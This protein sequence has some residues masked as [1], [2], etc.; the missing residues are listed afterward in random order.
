MA[1]AGCGRTPATPAPAANTPPPVPASTAIAQAADTSNVTKSEEPVAAPA[2]KQAGTPVADSA[3]AQPVADD[4]P[5]KFLLFLPAG[6]LIVQLNMTIDGRPFH[7]AREELVDEV[8][9]LADADHDGNPTWN[10]IVADSKEAL[11]RRFGLALDVRDRKEF[12]RTH[13]TNQN[14]VLDRDEARRLVIRAKNA[15]EAFAL[16]SSTKY[17]NT[18]QHHSLILAALDADADGL[19][20]SGELAA[21]DV[22][23]LA[24]DANGDAIV[25]WDEIDDTLAGDAR[26]AMNRSTAYL[27]QP[28]ALVLGERADW[29][30]IVYVF[31]ELYL[32]GDEPAEGAF[33][34]DPSLV[35]RLDADG[36][37]HFTYEEV[38]GL[39]TFRPDLVL[40]ANFGQAGDLAAGVSLASAAAELGPAATS[41]A[42]ASHGLTLELGGYRVRFVMDDRGPQAPEDGAKPEDQFAVLDADKNG[43][44]ETKEIAE[45][46]SAD[47]FADWD[48]D[49]DDKVFLE[50]FV[51]FARGRE[52]PRLSAIQARVGDDHDVLFP[53]LDA[54]QDGRLTLR[55]L[56]RCREQLLPLDRDGDG[57]IDADELP[58]A[59]TVLLG[60]GL[61]AARRRDVEL[62]APVAAATSAGPSWFTHLDTNHDDEVSAEEFPGSRAKFDQIDIDRDGFVTISEAQSAAAAKAGD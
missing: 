22:R 32:S 48:A 23:L 54:N 45:T 56:R 21:A 18:N 30:A 8:L 3:D 60:R 47:M 13:D 6:P 34:L 10:E 44:L 46:D 7:A 24:R 29:D 5:P 39:D 58:G 40:A 52:A 19:L 55:E 9:R 16:T 62:T 15:G 35:E 59:I 4:A 11:K 57:Q 51:R 33:T 37:Q 17:R 12:L 31:S 49:G 26:E 2:A 27:D 25:T 42:Y 41:P 14:G 50:E 61:P 36:D 38:R 43:Y 28:A 53:L 1:L 20:S